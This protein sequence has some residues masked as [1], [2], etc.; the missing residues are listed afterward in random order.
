[1]PLKILTVDDKT[2]IRMIVKRA[3]KPYD[4]EIL[5]AENGSEA[6]EKIRGEKPDLILLD[7]DMPVMDGLDVLKQIN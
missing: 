6:L 4:C 2:T 3:L 1:M 7:V 5:E